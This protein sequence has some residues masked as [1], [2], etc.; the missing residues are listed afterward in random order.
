MPYEHMNFYPYFGWYCASKDNNP[1]S[2]VENLFVSNYSLSLYYSF[3]KRTRNTQF[4]CIFFFFLYQ[5]TINIFE[6]GTPN[7]PWYENFITIY[8]EI[9]HNDSK[10]YDTQVSGWKNIIRSDDKILLIYLISQKTNILQRKSTQSFQN[11]QNNFVHWVRTIERNIIETLWI[12]YVQVHG[13]F[14]FHNFS[15]KNIL[16]A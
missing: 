3:V 4:Q 7:P 5:I 8:S 12:I 14:Y 2:S 16:C 13:K 11:A 6:N 10:L 9:M 15:E 1:L